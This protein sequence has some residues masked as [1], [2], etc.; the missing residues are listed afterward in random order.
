MLTIKTPK[1]FC[2][3]IFLAFIV[4][5]AKA[6]TQATTGFYEIN[7]DALAAAKRALHSSREKGI[8]DNSKIVLVDFTK[9]SYEKRLWVIDLDSNEVIHNTWVSH[10][11][12]SGLVYANS[13]SNTPASNKSSIGVFITKGS[14]YGKHG[15]S[16]GIEGLEP[17]FNSN[18]SRRGV[19]MHTSPY[20]GEKF[21]GKHGRLGRSL[22]CFTMEPVMGKQIMNEVEQDHLIVAYY[23]DKRWLDGSEFIA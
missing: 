16:I 3:F 10:G 11:K 2:I 7:T 14:Y 20:A 23:P 21:L 13:F 5:P 9:P 8:T 22:G 12:N 6:S 17:G 4:L 19:I 1:I 15:L 18:A